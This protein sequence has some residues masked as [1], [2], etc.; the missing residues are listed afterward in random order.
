MTPKVL[1]IVLLNPATG[2]VS[3]VDAQAQVKEA[4][5]EFFVPPATMPVRHVSPQVQQQQG[6]DANPGDSMPPKHVAAFAKK[7][8]SE[9]G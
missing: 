4:A 7:F 3:V 8:E 5:V 9:L 2:A 6:T 1:A